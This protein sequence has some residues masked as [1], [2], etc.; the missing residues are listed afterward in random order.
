MRLPGATKA[1]VVAALTGHTVGQA[2]W[3]GP[4]GR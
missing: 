2:H 1:Q 4:Y 3:M